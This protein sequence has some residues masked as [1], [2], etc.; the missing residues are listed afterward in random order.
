MGNLSSI[1]PMYLFNRLSI[2]AWT[3]GYLFYILGYNPILL[4]FVAPM[5]H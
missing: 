1:F 2:S 5:S 3:H 4:Y